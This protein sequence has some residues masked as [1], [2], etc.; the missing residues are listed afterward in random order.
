MRDLYYKINIE[1]FNY[2][3]LTKCR[4]MLG[5]LSN[6]LRKTRFQINEIRIFNMQ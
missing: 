5:N 4:S 1:S 2:K 3:S 6:L